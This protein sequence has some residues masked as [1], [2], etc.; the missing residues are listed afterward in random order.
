MNILNGVTTRTLRVCAAFFVVA[1][2]FSASAGTAFAVGTT[3]V[4]TSA[5]M[6]PLAEN[7]AD[8]TVVGTVVATDGDLDPLTYAITAGNTGTAFAINSATG[9]ITVASSAALDF[10]VTPTF[11]LTVTATDNEAPTPFVGSGTITIN[12][13]NVNDVAPVADADSYSVSAN[14]TLTVLVGDGVLVGDTDADLDPLTAVDQNAGV[15]ANG[16]YTLSSDGSFVYTPTPGY[17]GPDTFTYVAND[18]ANNSAVTT[19]TITVQQLAQS[20]TFSAPADV[21]YGDAETVDVSASSD[22]GGSYPVSFAVSGAGCSMF[23]ADTVA[24]HDAT[25]CTV[26]ASQAGDSL[27]APAVDVVDSFDVL[28]RAISVTAQADTKVYDGLNTSAV[29]PTITAGTLAFADSANF[30]QTYDS[31][32]VGAG[33]GMTAAGVV[34]D[35]NNGDNYDVTFVPAAVGTITKAPLTITADDKTKVY[36]DANP[37]TTATYDG[38]VNGEASSVLDTP[39][40]LVMNSSIHSDVGDYA[41]TAFGAADGNYDISYVNGNVAVTKRP[42]TVTVTAASKVYDGTTSTTA[43]LA[44]VGVLFTDVVTA[45][46][47]GATFDT[48][49][50]GSG[51]TVT[52]AGVTLGGADAG[53]YSVATSATGSADI[54]ARPLTVTAIANSKV[55]GDTD[56]SFSYTSD[57]VSGD[58]FTG[59]LSRD[60][61]EDT[62][63]YA[64]T[65]GTLDAGTNY[66]IT[67]TSASFTISPA[68]LTVTADD[69][70]KV[71]GSANPALTV[72]YSGFQGS[73]DAGDLDTAPTA[74]TSAVDSSD[75]GTYAITLSPG[76]DGNYV[77]SYTPGT[78][79][80]TPLAITVSVAAS[81]REYD[82]T[83]DA[84]VVLTVNGLLFGDSVEASHT[85]ADFADADVG[86]AKT[87][88]VTGITLTGTDAGNYSTAASA[89]GSAN[90]SVRPITVTADASTKV[91]GT[92]DPAFTY[93]ITSGSL[94]GSDLLSGALARDA[95]EDVGTY[96]I[97]IDTLAAGPNYDLDFV[98]ANLSITPAT[99]TATADDATR[100]YNAANPSF[101]VTYVGFVNGDDEGDLDTLATASTLATSLSPVGTY[102]IT[103]SGAADANYTVV[104]TDGTLTVVAADQTISFGTLAGMNYGDADFLVS[105]TA[106]SGLTVSFTATGACTV[107]GTTVHLTTKGT[108]TIT[109]SQAGDTNWNAAVDVAQSFAVDDV[110][111]PVI[112]LVGD[113]V[114]TIEKGVTYIDDG[115]TATDDVDGDVTA[116]IV[117]DS[118]VDVFTLGTYTVT[119]DVS[120]SS[121]NAAT[122]AT[123]TVTVVA[124]TTGGGGGGSN[125][126]QTTA[127]PAGRVLGASSYNFSAN[128]SLGSTGDDV[129][130]LQKILIG[131]GHLKVAAPTG[132]FGAM[133]LAAV[134]AYQTAHGITPASGFVGPIT[135]ALLNQGAAPATTKS[136]AEQIA[137]L[138]AKL[139]ALQAMLG[140]Q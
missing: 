71:Y 102:A 62:G 19:V 36:G 55:Y 72:S 51:K 113:S 4:V 83:T 27:Y 137:E 110:T 80:V 33:I 34:L 70:T 84:T 20:I 140:Q 30:S 93:Q 28:P 94:A 2:L 35:G 117:A 91:Y 99:L 135:R 108:C 131:E 127:A 96:A 41:I 42:V 138:T 122:Q 73:D 37:A 74:L 8:L 118:G 5:V 77:F 38:L 95:G 17:A 48:K 46:H 10:E 18:G 14:G 130:E 65:Q 40:T 32:N 134:K 68:T 136:V 133:T 123:R 21:T 66:T 126:G 63:T 109:A 85:D 7:S 92:V 3:P 124:P 107:S 114:Q 60:S 132:Y 50:V 116:S 13:S 23:D 69:A 115:A 47:T 86:A 98:G 15:S 125:T 75:A 106:D 121:G 111:A 89:T 25:T 78:L 59:L 87:V 56:P 88:T 103:P 90:I 100:A 43:T 12:L 24:F 129:L 119:Y 6:A 58:A 45:S 139:K 101:T 16:T 104:H 67:F 11:S 64:M 76:V 39:V 57:I 112:T 22:A 26:T 79:T 31:V 97:T 81:N 82:A 61:G 128:L 105:A 49:H 52:T 44:P 120:D 9:E 1:F 29:P 53:N 54:T